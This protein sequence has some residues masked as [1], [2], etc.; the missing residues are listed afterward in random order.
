MDPKEQKDFVFGNSGAGVLVLAK[1]TGRFLALK[2]SDHVQHSR[3]WALSGGLLEKGETPEQG[4]EREFREETSFDGKV[5]SITPLTTFNSGKFT[6]YNFIAV[7]EHEFKPTLDH[8]NE[9]FEWVDSLDKWPQPSH[10]GIDFLKQDDASM[11]IIREQR[12]ACNAQ[13]EALAYPPTLY[14]V[15]FG[16][17]DVQKIDGEICA[18][19]NLRE[20]LPRLIAR[21]DRL[22]TAPL[23]GSEDF[24]VV[25][26]DREKFM[27]D[28]KIDGVIFQLAGEGFGRTSRHRWAKDGPLSVSDRNYFDHVD[29]LDAAMYYGLHV[30][31]TPGP[32]SEENR[33]TLEN[34]TQ[35]PD[36]PANIKN[37]VKDGTLI[38]ENAQRGIRVSPQLQ[39]ED[40]PAPPK[41]PN[42]RSLIH[43]G[44]H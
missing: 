10:F 24:I 43:F 29:K 13:P 26:P 20:A 21:K 2:R 42:P 28:G 35:A 11:R 18:T 37:L 36:F 33:K 7:L 23:P 27:K 22:V 4:A 40:A 15:F 44:R 39:P 41:G 16:A 38:Y 30:F 9:A 14:H 31:F 19:P 3:S 8:E 32:V 1:D 34:A 17:A 12:A 25:I 6:Y 5:S